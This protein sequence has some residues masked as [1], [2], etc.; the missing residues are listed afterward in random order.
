MVKHAEDTSVHSQ[1]VVEASID[2]AF[3]VFTEGIG[4]W[5]PP[6]Y[7]MLAVPIAERVF[8]P[9]AGGRVYDRGTD[10]SECQWARVLVYEP[11]N[12]VVIGWL[13]SPHWQIETDPSKISEVD[14]RFVSEAP[15]RTR[16]EL[17]HRHIDRH[18]EGWQKQR[19]ELGAE[20][21]WPGCMRRYAERFA[22]RT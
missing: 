22:A 17:E 3:S 21:G 9:R 6:E 8:E 5:M 12:R 14:V 11:P 20:G 16:V 2:E 7:N 1:V 18:G 10:G 19:D 4:T 13:I 15:N